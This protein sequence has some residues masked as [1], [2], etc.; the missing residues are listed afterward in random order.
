MM[1]MAVHRLTQVIQNLRNNSLPDESR[2]ADGKLLDHF[3][4]Y[5]DESAF[6][7]LMQRHGPMVWGVCRRIV[8][9]HQDAED[10]FQA[11]FL[12]LARKAN[13]IRPREMVANWLY[14]VAH[15]TALKAKTMAAKRYTREKQVTTMPEPA[16]AEQSAWGN[17]ESLIDQEVANL[18]DKYRVAIVLCDLEGK[19]GKDVARQLRIPEGTL[20]SRLRTGRVILAK[21]L[22]RHGVVLSGGA[23]AALLSQNAASACAPTVLVT[24]TIKAASLTAAG[25]TVAAGIISANAAA[26]MEGVMK[27]MLLTKLKTVLVMLVVLGMGAFGGGQLLIHYA[28]AGQHDRTSKSAIHPAGGENPTNSKVDPPVRYEAVSL[29]RSSTLPP[30]QALVSLQ[31]GKLVVRTIGVDSVTPVTKVVDGRHVT[32]YV[33]KEKVTLTTYDLIAIKVYDVMGKRVDVRELPKLLNKEIVA[34]I[35]KDGLEVDPLHLRLFKEG[36]LLFLLPLPDPA[37]P[38]LIAIPYDT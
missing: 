24:A 32:S 21:R 25:K 4:E 18:S 34:L 6:A 29:P 12:V 19:K 36:T 5:H 1:N 17:L 10:A 26:L 15:R 28:E 37:T 23:L 31:N 7:G 11:T 33:L 2:A 3:I 14:G 35:S 8:S 27:A 22:A 16:A 30:T 13:S 38:P 9:H 20:A